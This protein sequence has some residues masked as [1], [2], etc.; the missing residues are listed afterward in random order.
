MN[1]FDAIRTIAMRDVV[2]GTSAYNIRYILRWYSKTFYTPLRDAEMIPLNDVFC[3]FFESRYEEM[4]EEDREAEIFDL[5]LSE[6]EKDKQ[7]KEQEAEEDEAD[8]FAAEAQEEDSSKKPETMADL[9]AKITEPNV[10][11]NEK[12]DK[13]EDEVPKSMPGIEMTF[14]DE[15]TFE[16]T[17]DKAGFGPDD[18][19]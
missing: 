1:P 18:E 9:A 14:V 17:L 19:K 13:I 3:H 4:S 5:L 11:I 16:A 7:L 10:D 2:E 12:E 8:L 6:D 15:D